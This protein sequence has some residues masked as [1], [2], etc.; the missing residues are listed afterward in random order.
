MLEYIVEQT[1]LFLEDMPKSKR[2]KKGQFFT[3]VETARF[4]SEMFDISSCGGN[5]TVLDPGSG[6][7]I[8]AV[9]FIDKI[10][11]VI[12]DVHIS[13]TCY[14]TDEDVLPILKANLRYIKALLGDKLDY[15]ILEE[16][17]ILSQSN[18]FD[19]NLLASIHPPKYDYVICIGATSKTPLGVSPCEVVVLQIG[20]N[21]NFF[22][23][24]SFNFYHF[25]KSSG[26]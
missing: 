24:R 22:S 13:L 25:I 11:S 7:G 12:H 17:Y 8:L 4:M 26:S 18:D 5:I 14:E 16:D 15:E 3:S 6:T 2:K 19:E 21:V 23:L 1:R 20:R 9:A 10:I